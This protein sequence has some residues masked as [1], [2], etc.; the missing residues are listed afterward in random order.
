MV[1]CT[2]IKYCRPAVVLPVITGWYYSHRILSIPWY[3]ASG[4]GLVLQL[5]DTVDLIGSY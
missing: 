2:A 1:L 3:P 5:L 4:F